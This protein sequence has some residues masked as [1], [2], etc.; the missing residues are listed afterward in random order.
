MILAIDNLNAVDG[1]SR[2][3]FADVIAEPPLAAML[4]LATHIPGFDPDW[5]GMEHRAA[6]LAHRGRRVAACR[7][8]RP[9]TTPC[10]RRP[11]AA[12][13]PPTL[14]ARAPCTRSTSSSS[15]ASTSR[16][17]AT[18]QHMADLI[19]LRIE[20]LPLEARRTLQALAVIGNVADHG[21]LRY[22]LRRSRP[23]RSCSA[24]WSSRA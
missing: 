9:R 6:R 14:R 23:S 21:S 16:A 19:A 15:F 20:R 3:A 11:P 17:G 2:T 24:P 13:G 12:T 5:A 7:G 22:L 4:I 8:M 18:R 10:S 1:S